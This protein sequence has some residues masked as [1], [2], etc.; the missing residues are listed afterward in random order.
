MELGPNPL[1][2]FNAGMN[3]KTDIDLGLAL[4]NH[5]RFECRG[6]DGQV[7]WV[8]EFDNLVVTVGK[9]DLLTQYFKGSAY[10][11]AFYV[12]LKGTGTVAAGDTMASHIGWAES[13]AYSN[14]A[15][16]TLTLGTAAS[17]SIDNSAVVAAFNI[18]ATAT[19]AGGFVATDSTKGGTVGTLY[20]AGDFAAARS[21]VSGDTLNVTITLT[22]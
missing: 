17:G 10:T 13:T 6:A 14:A 20:G 3:M 7:K 2:G 18:N 8:E 1:I 16:P 11:A 9:N 19:I 12:G 4:E 22:A 21:V 5:Y 15:R